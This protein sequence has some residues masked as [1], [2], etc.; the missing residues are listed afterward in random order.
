MVFC[1]AKH[2]ADR[3]SSSVKKPIAFI[4]RYSLGLFLVHP[5][6]LWPVRTYDWY[7][8]HSAFMVVSLVLA[9]TLATLLV[10]WLMSRYKV[11]RWLVP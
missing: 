8:G 9:N 1:L 7:W 2:Y 5:L 10:V 6:L 4:S 3:L 11:T